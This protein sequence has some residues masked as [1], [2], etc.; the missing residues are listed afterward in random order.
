MGKCILVT[1]ARCGHRIWSYKL[2]KRPLVVA[3]CS[4]DFGSRCLELGQD[5][6]SFSWNYETMSFPNLAMNI[7]HFF[8]LKHYKLICYCTSPT[9]F[10]FTLSSITGLSPVS[11]DSQLEPYFS[12]TMEETIRPDTY[13]KRFSAA[14]QLMTSQMALKYSALRF[15]Y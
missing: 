5:G 15:S 14:F 2:A 6:C 10:K 8:S 3:M 9:I 11:C 1:G 4:R 7:Y 13:L 12:E